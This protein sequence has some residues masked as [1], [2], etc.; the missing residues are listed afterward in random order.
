MRHG[1]SGRKTGDMSLKEH[2]LVRESDAAAF[3]IDAANRIVAWNQKARDLLGFNAQAV[4]GR[5][6]ADVIE[7]TDAFG[8]RAC[9][10]NC[11]FHAMAREHQDIEGH[12]LQIRGADGRFVAIYATVQVVRSPGSAD[13]A[14]VFFLRPERRRQSVDALLERLLHR[15]LAQEIPAETSEVVV[16]DA[17]LTGR[18][19]QVLALVAQGK[20]T[21]EV[22][23]T[24]GVSVNTVRRH[25]QNVLDVLHCHSQ[26]EAVAVAIRQQ[27][28]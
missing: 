16:F 23:K 24:I 8:N 18:Q 19:R 1:H 6:G 3:A 12:T 22:A 15:R 27:W 28:I 17:H 14:L 2:R 10:G 5:D 25:M 13:H 11:A 26:A 7:A 20:T 4:V 21:A 9:P